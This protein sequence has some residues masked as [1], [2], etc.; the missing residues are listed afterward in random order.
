M[1]RS[2]IYALAVGFV[3][4]GIVHLAIILSVPRI[5][6][7]DAWD[8]IRTT[9][10]P[11][12][13]QILDQEPGMAQTVKSVDPLFDIAAC[14]FLLSEGPVHLATSTRVAFWSLSIFGEDGISVFSFNDRNASGGGLDIVVA[15]PAEAAELRKEIPEGLE[16]SFLVEARINGGY[17]VLRAFQPDSSWSGNVA[18]FLRDAD[19]API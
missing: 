10:D 19:C 8:R 18:R 14:H 7:K 5:T 4:A 6:D 1:L 12:R 13:F 11:Y 15:T 9:M 3:G 17:A 2:L 16:N